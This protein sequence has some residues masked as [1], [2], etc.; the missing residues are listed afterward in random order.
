MTTVLDATLPA[1]VV[2]ILAT[3]GK[4]ITFVIKSKTYDPATGLTTLGTPTNHVL[5]GSPP[6]PYSRKFVDGDTVRAEDC[7]TIIKGDG[8]AFT[9]VPGMQVT[10]DGQTWTSVSVR[11]YYSGELVAAWEVQLRR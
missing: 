4:D 6:Y 10:F 2:S 8:L 7:M 9:P 3:Y 5:K 11:P 1:Q